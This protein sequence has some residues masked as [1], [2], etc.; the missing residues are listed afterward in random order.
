MDQ[1]FLTKKV[2]V[3]N[4]LDQKCF[5]TN[6]FL[7]PKTFFDQQLFQFKFWFGLGKLGFGS[8]S[9]FLRPTYF[10][11]NFLGTKTFWDQNFCWDQQFLGPKFWGLILFG[12]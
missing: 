10:E 6:I 3:E 4:F 1:I 2:Y 9:I 11:S 7:S 12:D 8:I 5:S